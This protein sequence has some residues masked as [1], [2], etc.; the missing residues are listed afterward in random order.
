MCIYCMV[1]SYYIQH[2]CMELCAPLR[3]CAKH[4]M[5]NTVNN[6][7]SVVYS[8]F[9]MGYSTNIA[10]FLAW[11]TAHTICSLLQLLYYCM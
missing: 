1:S 7:I 5:L 4:S 8:L 9:A 2:C 3:I 6:S 11:S 10:W